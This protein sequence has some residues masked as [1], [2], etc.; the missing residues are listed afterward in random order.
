MQI[1]NQSIIKSINQYQSVTQQWQQ[2][3]NCSW[4]CQILDALLHSCW[5]APKTPHARATNARETGALVGLQ[6]PPRECPVPWWRRQ[7]PNPNGHRKPKTTKTKVINKW[8]AM[9]WR[10]PVLTKQKCKTIPNRWLRHLIGMIQM[11]GISYKLRALVQ[12][13]ICCS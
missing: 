5:G 13:S 8:N 4:S 11:N 6:P 2:Y 7:Y 1:N 12:R 9:L 10:A 3:C